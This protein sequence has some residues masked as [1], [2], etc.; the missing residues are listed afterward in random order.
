M[1]CASDDH[2]YCFLYDETVG[3]TGPNEVISLLDHL[4]VEL[5]NKLGKHDHLIIWCDNAPGQ[6]KECFLFF[7]LD[8]IVRRGQLLRA[9]L[10]FL[11]E[12]HTYSVCDRRFG[13]IQNVFQRHE[14]IDIPRKWAT[15]LEHEGL[16]NVTVKWVTLDMIKDY[17]SFLRLRYVSRNEDLEKERFE[18]KNIA[19]LNFGYGETV[20]ENGDLQLVHHP[21]NVFVRFEMDSRQ[22]P[23]KISFLKKKQCMELRPELLTTVRRERRAIREDVKRSCVKLAQKYL[24]QPAIRFYES[25][26]SSTSE[27]NEG[28]ELQ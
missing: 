28:G 24:S 26:P 18:V 12:G 21:D 23:R 11:L 14:I 19:W 2:I 6:F 10:K 7:Y 22:F 20:D 17:K 4:L 25:L 3:T 16:S 15:V 13:T 8:F 27:E 5:E 1:Y 9:D